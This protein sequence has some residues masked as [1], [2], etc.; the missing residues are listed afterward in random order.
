MRRITM[1]ICVL[2]TIFSAHAQE[3]QTAG[4]TEFDFVGMYDGSGNSQMTTPLGV[5]FI[6]DEKY[7]S[8]RLQPELAFGKFG[9]GLDIPLM[10]D[11]SDGSFRTDEFKDGVGPLRVVRYARYGVKHKDPFYARVGDITGTNLGYGLI[12]FN[13][14]NAVSFDKRQ[15][16]ANVDVN[17]NRQ[18]GLEA[19]YSDFDGVNVVGVRPYWRPFQKSAVPLVKSV[20]F[21]A[22]YIT[23]R[24]PDNYYDVTE[25]GVDVGVTVLENSFVQIVPYIEYAQILENSALKD[26]LAA[27]ALKVPDENGDALAG[28][29]TDVN[30]GGGRGLA[31]GTNFKFRLVADVFYL[32]TKIERRMYSDN[33]IGQ[34]FDPTYEAGKLATP[35]V[36]N[37]QIVGGPRVLQLAYAKG[38]Q[39][40]YGEIY[41]NLINKVQIIGA[42]S[43]PDNLKKTDGATLHIGMSAPELIPKVVISGSYD[44]GRL[45]DLADAFTLDQRSIAH[46]QF[47]YKIYPYLISGVDYKYTFV[48]RKSGNGFKAKSYMT[49]FVALQFALPVGDQKK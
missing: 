38:V 14:T 43:I 44:K 15:I 5:A 9:I 45:D 32:G 42:M 37:G 22:S 1:W 2:G 7:I 48:E 4:Q 49:P 27:G 16:G 25:V 39:G 11:A 33:F 17:Y 23:D 18:F 28:F 40:T 35:S 31:I 26:D 8:L 13:Y 36:A 47:G 34:F 41:G 20:E 21:G 30:Y 19:V 10:F 46:L 3:D 24:D 6:G 12:M 29:S